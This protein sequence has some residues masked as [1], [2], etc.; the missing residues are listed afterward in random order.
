V[1]GSTGSALGLLALRLGRTDEA[2][3]R[4]REALELHPCGG[5][6]ALNVTTTLYLAA[7][8]AADGRVDDAVRLG[9]E[10]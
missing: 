3:S 10:V 5:D 4:M 6:R 7:A 1:L 2:V 9:R 8:L